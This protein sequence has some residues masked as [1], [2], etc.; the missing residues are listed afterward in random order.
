M[1]K[2]GV[3]KRYARAFYEAG[4]SKGTTERFAADL[5]LIA[6]ALVDYPVL[7]SFLVNPLISRADKQ[8]RL[9]AVFGGFVDTQTTNLLNLLVESGRE[10][11]LSQIAQEFTSLLAKDQ[12][13]VDAYVESAVDMTDEQI[14][15]LSAALVTEGIKTVRC[16]VQ[17]NPSIIGGLRV[18]IG[19]R[20]VDASIAGRLESIREVFE[21]RNIS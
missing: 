17:V 12:G 3:A 10:M 1:L 14:Q 11:Y 13:L 18:R 9:R 21:K 15:A 5:K 4:Q 16:H 8:S 7:Q 6:Q 20:V 19:D 2:P